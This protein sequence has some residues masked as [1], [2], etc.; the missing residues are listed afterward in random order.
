[1]FKKSDWKI[2]KVPSSTN[3]IPSPEGMQYYTGSL[4]INFLSINENTVIIEE[5]DTGIFEKMNIKSERKKE[6]IA[7]NEVK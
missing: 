3:P 7:I 5:K 6:R 1:M 4:N 2:F